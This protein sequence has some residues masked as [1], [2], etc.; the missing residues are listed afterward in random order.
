MMIKS[1]LSSFIKRNA[2]AVAVEFAM[3]A[4]PLFA[5]M[6]GITEAGYD[7]FMQD[8]LDNAA[9]ETARQVLTGAAQNT[10]VNGAAPDQSYFIK[11]FVCS[12]LPGN[13]ACSNVVVN[14]SDFAKTAAPTPYYN[15]VNAAK[16]GLIEPPL[17]NAQTSYCMGSTSAYVVLQILYPVPVF[18][19]LFAR[20]AVQTF[21]G[22]T[23]RV[24]TATAVFRNEPFPTPANAGC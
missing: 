6:L 20:G 22:H 21:Q 5:L 8:A 13:F 16:T 11:N 17:D 7:L 18:T 9:H 2:G 19:G 23:V 15:Y 3:I 24:L 14:V 4:G 10:S 1:V 12:K